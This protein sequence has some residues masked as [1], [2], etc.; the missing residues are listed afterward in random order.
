MARL[1]RLRGMTQTELGEKIGTSFRMVAYY[2]G[3]ADRP[4]AHLLDKL[5][6]VLGASADEL[7]GLKAIQGDAPINLRIWRRFRIIEDLSP[8]DRHLVWK[9]IRGLPSARDHK[10]SSK[11]R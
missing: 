5:A 4:P 3:Q 10:R 7:L 9:F 6:Q 11:M 1:R 2:E 8:A